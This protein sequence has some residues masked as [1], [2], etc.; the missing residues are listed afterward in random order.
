MLDNYPVSCKTIATFFH[1]NGKQ[2]EHQY[3]FYLS[4]FSTWDQQKHAADWV[5][6]EQNISPYLSIDETALSQGE[7]YTI[8]TNKEAKGRKGALVAMIKGTDSERIN[9]IIRQIPINK[10]Q[11]VKEVT[12]DMAASME[13]VVRRSFPRAQLVTDRFHVQKLAYDAVQEMRIA[14]RWEAMDIGRAHV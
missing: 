8:I 5:L 4:D 7:L 10:R 12:L 9:F 3:L 13:K 14:Y 11:M 1:V 6:F 2:L